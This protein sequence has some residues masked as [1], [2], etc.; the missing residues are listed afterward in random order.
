MQQFHLII[1]WSMPY[2]LLYSSLCP[3][4]SGHSSQLPQKMLW[5]ER[6]TMRW[7]LFVKHKKCLLAFLWRFSSK[8]LH[9]D[10]PN[11]SNETLL[12]QW[13]L[14]KSWPASES[15]FFGHIY[16]R[17]CCFFFTH[18]LS[19]EFAQK[20]LLW[21]WRWWSCLQPTSGHVTFKINSTTSGQVTFKINSSNSI[22]SRRARHG[23]ANLL[24][25][26]KAAA[27]WIQRRSLEV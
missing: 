23:V 6:V 26:W 4:A 2:I 16:V 15:L 10:K 25:W 13:Y 18:L 17:L 24:W 19:G 9:S 12:W 1:T 5:R 14:K 27:V 21:T 22:I 3:L 20:T 11:C 8:Y 7:E